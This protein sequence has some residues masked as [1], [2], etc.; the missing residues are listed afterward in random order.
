MHLLFSFL[1]NQHM[2]LALARQRAAPLA[3]IIRR[4]PEVPPG[5]QWLNFLRNHDEIDLGRLSDEEREEVYEAFGPEEKMR[6][7][8]RGIRRRLAPMLD[9]DRRRLELAF[10]LLFTLPGTPMLQYGDEI[11]LGDDLAL[12][13]RECARTPMQWSGEKNGGFSTAA[14]TVRPVISDPIY[15]YRRVNV[16]AQRRDPQSFINW[17]ER[18]IRMRRE[19][20]EI[21]WGA[22]R[23]LDAEASGVLAMRYDFAGQTLVILHNFTTKSR[24]ARL[25]L[26]AAGTRKLTDLLWTND[27]RVDEAGRHHIQLEPYGYRWFRGGGIDHNVPRD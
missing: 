8:G 20:P 10:S 16:E 25:D 15:G 1:V 23:I 27:S 13:E 21:S 17:V 22:W 14:R 2:M 5:G 12:P 7:Y 24:V 6:A 3:D 26:H 4:L 9:N 11:G 19:C 18:K